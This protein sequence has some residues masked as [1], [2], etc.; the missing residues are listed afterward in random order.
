MEG[1]SLFGSAK[2]PQAAT[3][4]AQQIL[5]SLKQL[6]PD[7][8]SSLRQRELA[9]VK[10]LPQTPWAIKGVL[11]SLMTAVEQMQPD[12][13][14]AVEMSAEDFPLHW[15]LADIDAAIVNLTG[16]LG[17]YFPGAVLTSMGGKWVQIRLDYDSYVRW[18]SQM[19]RAAVDG[20]P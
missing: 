13:K 14:R 6:T 3:A 20:L 16:P 2:S 1:N 18:W 19:G 8:I 9:K 15:A 17:V 7:L 11:P 10:K 4:I 5:S 12:L